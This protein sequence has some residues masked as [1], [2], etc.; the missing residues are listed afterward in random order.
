MKRI[1]ACLF[2]FLPLITIAQKKDKNAIKAASTITPDA[3]KKHLYVIAGKEMEGRDTPSPGLEKAA[4]YIEDH[5]KALGL[6]AGNNGSYRQYYPLF[7]DSMIGASL[8]VNGTALELNKDY[9]P[10]ANNYAA[11]MRFSEVVFAGY[12]II[13]ADKRDDYKDLKVAGKL[14][15]ILD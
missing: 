6:K 10:Q 1:F 2:F 5:F 4:N 12:G 15:V 11:S 14:V 7:R 9:Q 8:K 3:L 13:D